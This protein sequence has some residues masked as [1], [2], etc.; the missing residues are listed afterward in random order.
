V[1]NPGT[2]LDLTLSGVPVASGPSDIIGIS[3]NQL[4]YDA[5]RF[6]YT[7]STP[8]DGVLTAILTSKMVGG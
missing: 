4:P 8:G 6:T 3:L 1:V 5:I 7:P 2:W